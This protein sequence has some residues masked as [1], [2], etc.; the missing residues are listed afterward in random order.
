MSS[1]HLTFPV[2][3]LRLGAAQGGGPTYLV[4]N[5]LR[6]TL[7]IPPGSTQIGRDGPALSVEWADGEHLS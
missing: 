5:R 4:E 2:R 6:P 1:P 7:P 3:W